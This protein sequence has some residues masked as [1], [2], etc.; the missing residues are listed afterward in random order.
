MCHYEYDVI[1][2]AHKVIGVLE[3]TWHRVRPNEANTHAEFVHSKTLP[4]VDA[5]AE[6]KNGIVHV[7]VSARSSVKHIE[8]FKGR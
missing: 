2:T 1:Q 4:Q 7:Q 5:E 6:V 8:L 3:K